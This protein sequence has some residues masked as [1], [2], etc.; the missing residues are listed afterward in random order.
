VRHGPGAAPNRTSR[1]GLQLN[2]ILLSGQLRACFSCPLYPRAVLAAELTSGSDEILAAPRTEISRFTF[3][4]RARVARRRRWARAGVVS[5]RVKLTSNAQ[6]A[7]VARVR[8][9]WSN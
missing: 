8:R 9:V 6:A 1:L 7:D 4:N 2:S 5:S 3:T